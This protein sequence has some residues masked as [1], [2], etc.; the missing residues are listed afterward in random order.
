MQSQQQLRGCQLQDAGRRKATDL[1]PPAAVARR[2]AALAPPQ[3]RRHVILQQPLH[4]GGFLHPTP[5]R[6]PVDNRRGLRWAAACREVRA[7]SGPALAQGNRRCRAMQGAGVHALN[8][9]GPYRVAAAE[10]RPAEPPLHVAA[11]GGGGPPRC[12]LV[13]LGDSGVGK[14]CIVQVRGAAGAAACCVTHPFSAAGGGNLTLP[15][16][17]PAAAAMPKHLQPREQ[18]HRGGG[19]PGAHPGAAQRRE[20]QV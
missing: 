19:L 8:H 17:P 12:K 11:A 1:G 3:W 9:R 16:E 15:F 7:L 20:R 18:R 4:V 5:R 6:R 2:P 13:L 10:L 14:S